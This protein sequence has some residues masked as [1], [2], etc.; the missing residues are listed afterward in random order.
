MFWQMIKKE[1]L[2][3]WRRPRELIVLLLMPFVLITILGSAL[4][5]FN[6]QEITIDASLALLIKDDPERAQ[7][8]IITEIQNSSLTEAEKMEQIAIVQ[9]FNP[10]DI[11]KNEL[12]AN[13]ELEKILK[14]TEVKNDLTENQI[15]EYSG[16]LEI[17]ADFSYQFYQ[18]LINGSGSVKEWNV[19]ISDSDSIEASVIQDII[20]SFQKELS[21]AKTSQDLQIDYSEVITHVQNKGGIENVTKKK[22]VDAFSYYAV[23]MCVMFVF[24]VAITVVESAF[25]QKEEHMYQRI[26]L[27]NVSSYVFYAGIF[28]ATFLL[29]F[30]QLHVLFSLTALIYGVTFTN[31]FYYFCVTLFL[32]IMTASFAVFITALSYATN[33]KEVGTV[34]SSLIIPVLAFVGGSFFDLSALGGVMEKLGQFSPGGA[35]I[36]AYIKIYQGYSLSDIVGQLQAILLFTGILLLLA[37][38]LIRKRGA[39]S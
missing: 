37:V 22:E 32:N 11:F 27:A 5:A 19:K 2:I 33:S 6:D 39:A 30:I 35:A 14:M 24:Y 23:G 1:L 18:R 34:F 38:V 13:K 25:Q 28:V 20:S 29:S 15:K 36:T 16:L 4:G 31:L 9:T 17:P 3:I 12:A 21:F 10:V 8:K 7:E 26:L